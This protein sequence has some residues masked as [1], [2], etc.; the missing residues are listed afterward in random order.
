MVL[1]PILSAGG[2][3]VG[4]NHKRSRDVMSTRPFCVLVNQQPKPYFMGVRTMTG[5]M[6]VVLRR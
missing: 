5:I 3:V 2:E 4:L 6:R 1:S